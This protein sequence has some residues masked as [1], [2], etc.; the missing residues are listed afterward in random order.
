M[1]CAGPTY[2][3]KAG[4]NSNDA[5]GPSDTVNRDDVTDGSLKSS[6]CGDA[7][8]KNSPSTCW[9]TDKTTTPTG[10]LLPPPPR[11]PGDWCHGQGEPQPGLGQWRQLSGVRG[12][13]RCSSRTGRCSPCQLTFDETSICHWQ[14]QPGTFLAPGLADFPCFWAAVGSGSVMLSFSFVS[15]PAGVQGVYDDDVCYV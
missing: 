1:C 12:R 10:S 5:P 15:S 4:P 9:T 6:P 3:A 8:P 11:W 14:N 2:Q 13:A 7:S